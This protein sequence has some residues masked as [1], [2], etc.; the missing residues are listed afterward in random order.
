MHKTWTEKG[1]SGTGSYH[2]NFTCENPE[3]NKNEVKLS[4]KNMWFVMYE[5]DAF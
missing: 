4:E 1:Y 3:C 5:P 2:G